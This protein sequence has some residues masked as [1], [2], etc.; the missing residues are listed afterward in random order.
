MPG[1]KL[2]FLLALLAMAL[3]TALFYAGVDVPPFDFALV[4]LLLILLAVYFSG[5]FLLQYD[6]SRGFPELLRAGFQSAL[7]YAFLVSLFTYLF[8]KAIDTTAFSTYNEKLIQGFMEQGH[9]EEQAREKVNALYN[10]GSYT[11]LTF[12]GLFMAGSLNALVFALVHHKLLR[13]FRG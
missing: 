9:P 3:R 4:H 5:H 13:K 11:V 7:L 1:I 8:Y 6:P 12:F 10:A 2:T